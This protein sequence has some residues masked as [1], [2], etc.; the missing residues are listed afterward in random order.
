MIKKLCICLGVIVLLYGCQPWTSVPV[1]AYV[2]ISNYTVKVP[3]DG[4]QGT[5]NQNFTDMEVIANGTNYGIWPLGSKIPVIGSGSLNFTIK[6]V[7][8]INGVSA[9]RSTYEVMKGSDT[10][11]AVTQGQVT[12]I[13]PEFQYFNGAVF[14]LVLNFN[15]SGYNTNGVQMV[16]SPCLTCD[17]D[18]TIT[19][20][21]PGFSGASTDGCLAFKPVL[22]SGNGLSSVQTSAAIGLPKG[23][24]G[25][26]LEFN[27][28][29]NIP[30]SIAIQG[31]NVA[32]GSGLTAVT[33]CG[34]VYPTPTWQ[35][36][37]I[38]LTEQVSTLQSG[39]YYIYF[40]C[41]YDDLVVSNFA[42]IDNV[43]IVVAQ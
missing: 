1:P 14:P 7:V 38:Q 4:S 37:Y 34:G 25:I 40:S 35:K 28:M 23:G 24:V 27:Y 8:E 29:C 5:A 36:A 13:V 21:Y 2:Q 19:I 6:A 41:L 9:L 12:N 32:T 15:G 42:Y 33:S 31:D 43:K 17:T 39:Y 22:N 11:I 20:H 18:K 3:T 16:D 26:Y 10:I 30:I